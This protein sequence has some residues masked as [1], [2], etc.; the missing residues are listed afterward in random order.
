MSLESSHKHELAALK[1]LEKGLPND[2]TVFHGVHWSREYES[3]THFGE[4][5]FVVL[6]RAGEVLFI[7]QKNGGLEE[8]DVG[9]VKRYGSVE[10]NVA[11]QLHRSIHKVQDKFNSQHGRDRKLAVDYLIYCPDYRI[12]KL[13]AAGLNCERIV[14]ASAKDGL[15][16]RIQFLL[17]RGE[18]MHYDWGK[19]VKEFFHQTFDLVPDIH[20]YKGSQERQFVRQTGALSDVLTNLE[21]EPFR[22]RICG[23]AGTGKSL[24]ARRFLQREVNANRKVLLTCFNRPLA[25]RLKN[26]IGEDGEVSNF[27]KFCDDYLRSCGQRLEYITMESDPD[28][29][30]KVFDRILNSHIPEESK[31]DTLIIDEGQDFEEYWFEIIQLFLH[32]GANIL[33]LEDAEQ[34]LYD[35]PPVSL[36]GFVT[37]NSRINYRSP[38]SIVRFIHATSP[39]QFGQGNDLPGM[40]VAVHAYTDSDQ[41]PS[42]VGKIIQKLM[43]HRISPEDIVIL[44]C[45]SSQ[46]SVFKDHVVVGGI[47]L[48]R[49]T[50]E[51]DQRGRQKWTNGKLTFDSVNRFKGQEAPVVILVDVDPETTTDKLTRNERVLFCG[52]TRATQ[53]LENYVNS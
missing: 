23:G 25:D 41:Q 34:N 33:W 6:N 24:F 4:I 16:E 8:T 12:K 22:L 27:H 31:Y 53:R 20:A 32:K 50:G 3:W 2:Y 45:K 19:Q 52:M 36:E 26:S 43:K 11:Q 5:D 39:I 10:K 35:K 37:Y 18:G 47:E 28:F 14:D 48:R 17:D 30:Q 21:M 13:N 9:L 7:E 49:F 29:W 42:I 1:I 38:E 15:T 44:T 51:Y 40:G 46:S